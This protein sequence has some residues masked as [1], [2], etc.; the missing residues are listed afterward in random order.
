MPGFCA[1][2]SSRRLA[3]LSPSSSDA[4]SLVDEA[5][6]ALVLA[7]KELAAQGQITLVEG[8]NEEM[9]E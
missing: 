3:A 9:I 1:S 5:Q 7:A 2:S 8:R 6:A 4:C